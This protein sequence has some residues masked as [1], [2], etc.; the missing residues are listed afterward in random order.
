MSLQ[1]RTDY[2]HPNQ[3]FTVLLVL[4]CTCVSVRIYVFISI[5]LVKLRQIQYHWSYFFIQPIVTQLIVT[6]SWSDCYGGKERSDTK[7]FCQHVRTKHCCAVH[8]VRY[9]RV[10]YAV[11]HTCVCSVWVRYA[12][13][14]VTVQCTV[15][16][17]ASDHKP[18]AHNPQL[19]VRT[20]LQTE[21]YTHG[22]AVYVWMN[23]L[24]NALAVCEYV[25]ECVLAASY[26]QAIWRRGSALGP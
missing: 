19:T 5:W 6:L 12:C 26:L 15:Y 16:S 22:S 23:R 7:S 20:V 3:L 2:Q 8:A 13:Q 24:T 17:S 1:G 10:W 21:H 14:H 4:S 25:L 11:R 18:T 9:Y